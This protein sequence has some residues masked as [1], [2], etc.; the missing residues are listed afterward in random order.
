MGNARILVVEDDRDNM[1]LI[2]FILKREGYSVLEAYNGREGVQRAHQDH[3]DLII[4]DLAMPEM[5]GWTAASEIKSDPATQHIPI[6]VLTVRSLAEDRRR[7]MEAGCDAYFTKPINVPLL[8][9]HIA[10]YLE[11]AGNK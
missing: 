2:S 7:A 8:M 10:S 9:E 3:P 5:D 4:L 1:G 6:L 11:K